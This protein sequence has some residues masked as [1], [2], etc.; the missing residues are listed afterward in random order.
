[1]F[2]LCL[3]CTHST[4]LETDCGLGFIQKSDSKH[5]NS[6]FLFLI[7]NQN[8]G[9]SL[10]LTSKLLLPKFNWRCKLWSLTPNNSL[11]IQNYLK[12]RSTALCRAVIPREHNPSSKY[13]FS[14][15]VFGK[16]VVYKHTLWETGLLIFKPIFSYYFL[17]WHW[18]LPLDANLQ[19]RPIWT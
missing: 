16:L 12:N 11:Q 9:L 2:F 3:K 15:N 7:F 14:S 1:M 10:T 4:W 8:H 6:F 18:T 5:E 19:N 17:S 13:V